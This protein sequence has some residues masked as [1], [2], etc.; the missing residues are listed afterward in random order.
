ME[1]IDSS[2][3]SSSG[4]ANGINAS[5][6]ATLEMAGGAGEGMKLGTWFNGRSRASLDRT[7]NRY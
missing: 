4:N 2:T 3:S 6:L 5:N 1:D 7:E